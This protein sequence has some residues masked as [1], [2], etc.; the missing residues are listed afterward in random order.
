MTWTGKLIMAAGAFGVAALVAEPAAARICVSNEADR[1]IHIVVR[2]GNPAARPRPVWRG[3]FAR[4]ASGCCPVSHRACA[5]RPDVTVSYYLNGTT[6]ERRPPRG[7]T[8]KVPRFGKIPSPGVNPYIPI[9]YPACRI[10]AMLPN[11]FVRIYGAPGKFG[12]ELWD[13]PTRMVRTYWLGRQPP[14]RRYFFICNRTPQPLS[15]A[16][17]ALADARR[18]WTAAGW[19]TIDAGQCKNMTLPS[20]VYSAPVYVLAYTG[21]RLFGGG[22]GFFCVNRSATFVLERADRATCPPGLSKAGFLIR[23]LSPGTNTVTY[24]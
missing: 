21:Q 19:Y 6:A 9:D 15:A 11:G 13:S 12:C 16:I 5:D 22:N 14:L 23:S 10:A 2:G 20:K 24:N 3:S 8:I 18:G 7:P 4:G 1:E 17:A